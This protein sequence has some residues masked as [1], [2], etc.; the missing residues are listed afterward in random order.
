M[1]AT[2]AKRPI[3]R[4]VYRGLLKRCPKCGVGRVFGR[5]LK[6][7]H[8]CGHCNEAYAHIRTDDFAPWLTI[9][10]MGHILAPI[11]FHVEL[12]YSPPT[13]LALSIWIPAVII[14]TLLLLPIA[15]GVCLGF[16][17][18]LRLQGDEMQ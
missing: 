10:V 13:F 4:S 16:M 5:Y 14:L 3:W 9:I 8:A 18:A 2:N 17:W 1:N 7:A 12:N 11:I 15:K 6:P